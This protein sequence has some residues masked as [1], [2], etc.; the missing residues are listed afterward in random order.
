MQRVRHVRQ[1]EGGAVDVDL[2]G[3]EPAIAEQDH[4]IG[5]IRIRRARRRGEGH[6]PPGDRGDRGRRRHRAPGRLDAD[7]TGRQRAD[8]RHEDVD[9]EAEVAQQR[10]ELP[11]R[12]NDVVELEIGR[13]GLDRV[14]VA[15]LVEPEDPGELAR[16]PVIDGVRVAQERGEGPIARGGEERGVRRP[17][18]GR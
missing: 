16:A 3:A 14:R 18:S 2:E 17:S 9:D 6:L 7:P 12:G 10:R 4:A 15:R 1:L 8:A 13:C 5:E 11:E